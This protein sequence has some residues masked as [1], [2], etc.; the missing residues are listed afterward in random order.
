MP[1]ERS[2]LPV[3]IAAAIMAIGLLGSTMIGAGAYYKAKKLDNSISVNGSAER[4]IKSDKVKWTSSLSRSVSPDQLNQGTTKLKTDLDTVKK[5]MTDSG[6]NENEI[7]VQPPTI[8]QVCDNAQNVMYDRMGGQ[9]CGSS[10]ITGYNLQQ[11]I[12]I[13][14]DKVELVSKLAQDATTRLTQSNVLFTSAGVEY[15]FTG[16]AD[17][18]LDLLTEATKN[19]TER[20][21]RIVEQ[22]GAKLG[23]IAAASQGV[24]QITAVNSTEVSDYGAYDTSSI[25]KKVTAIVRTSFNLK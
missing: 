24:F 19:A 14:S 2:S 3:I 13:E 21:Q 17:L 8:T 7:T 11:A 15:Y 4:I 18:R 20:A 1:Q 5:L 9:F 16:L 12:I 22:T 6:L 23:G 25:D 10:K